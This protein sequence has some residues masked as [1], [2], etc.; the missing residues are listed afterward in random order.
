MRL[1]DAVMRTRVATED[2]CRVAIP[3]ASHDCLH[4][5][6]LFGS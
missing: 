6:H 4:D 1:T 2:Q 5:G 3:H